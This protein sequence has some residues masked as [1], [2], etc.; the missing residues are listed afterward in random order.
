MLLSLAALLLFFSL[1]PYMVYFFG[2]YFGKKHARITPLQ[3]YPHISIVISAYNEE[4]VIGKRIE[5]IKECHYPAERYELLLVD[6]CSG[7]IHKK[8]G[9]N[10]S[11]VFGN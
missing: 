2:I 4:Q 10:H 6:D 3:K 11:G 7:A 9:R 8:S 5:N 1:F